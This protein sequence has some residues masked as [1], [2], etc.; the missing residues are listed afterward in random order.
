[1]TEAQAR[2]PLRGAVYLLPGLEVCL[3]REEW[4]LDAEWRVG[5]GAE[6]WGSRIAENAEMFSATPEG[7]A[8][9]RLPLLARWSPAAIAAEGFAMVAGKPP[10]D[11][12]AAL[13][14]AAVSSRGAARRGDGG[15]GG[16]RV[17][18]DRGAGHAL[19]A[20]FYDF[21]PAAAAAK[22]ASNGVAQRGVT[23]NVKA[24]EKDKARRR[25]KTLAAA[26]AADG[27]TEELLAEPAA[28]E[29]QGQGSRRRRA[30]AKMFLETARTLGPS[31][32]ESM[33]VARRDQ[34][35][36]KAALGVLGNLE[37]NK[38]SLASLSAR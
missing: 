4:L 20:S 12:A 35:V 27:I 24:K 29:E 5:A 33:T 15:G 32:R 23:D 17:E 25:E 19:G 22:D 8:Y 13:A 28:P 3:F 34:D 1:M 6:V 11:A 9:A 31:E 30:E 26:F 14:A 18:A 10:D 37:R 7:F 21:G 2:H 36:K 38:A 16:A